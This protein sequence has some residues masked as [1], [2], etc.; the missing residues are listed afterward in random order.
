MKMKIFDEHFVK[1]NFIEV[2]TAL[3]TLQNVCLSQEKGNDMPDLLQR[4]ESLHALDATNTKKP[5]GILTIFG[6][7]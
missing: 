7:K 3:G 2:G 5:P 4:F 1:P 6:R